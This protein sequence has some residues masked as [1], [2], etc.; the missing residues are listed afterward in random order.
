MAI[1]SISLGAN[2]ADVKAVQEALNVWKANPPLTPN[3]VFDKDTD[4][5]VRRFQQDHGLKPDGI[6][7]RATRRALFPVGVATVTVQ[8]LR[9]QMPEAPRFRGS[10]ASFGLPP[11]RL[12]APPPVS[13][14]NQGSY[15]P[16]RFPGLLC[17]MPAPKT[18]LLDFSV[19]SLDPGNTSG[20]FLGFQFDHV[21][22]QP[23]AQTTV[24]FNGK[25][26]NVFVLTMQ[27]V[28]RRGPDNGAHKELDT[29]VTI[30][31][32]MV[33]P[34]GPWTVNPFVQLTD[35]DR[36]GAIGAFHWWQPYA[37]V[38]FQFMG[39][40]NAQPALTANL[41]PLNLGLDLGDLLT[42]TIAGGLALS[43]DLTTGRLV[44]G[45]QITGGLT[46]KLGK[47]NSPL[48]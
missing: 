9:L 22:L 30:T 43:L 19:P 25:A 11:L 6:V 40:G 31:S 48:W 26:Q 47:P 12:N 41:F 38:G 5:A 3:G 15:E 32:S 46:I 10:S 37:Q 17:R 16:V 39:L 21:E 45:P 36:F 18:P 28:Y 4:S 23:G 29:G 1:R 27:N 14:L 44:A 13:F 8:G 2:G 34:N 20:G 42:V 35:V 7:G 24:P 33:N